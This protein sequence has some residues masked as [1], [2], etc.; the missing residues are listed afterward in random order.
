[1]IETLNK[2]LVS[3]QGK[4]ILIMNPPRTSIAADDALLLAAYLVLMA[5]HEASQ[6]F[7]AV[8]KA[9]GAC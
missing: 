5:E 2:F 1:M 4:A 8:L 9:V 3:S 7:E 6:P